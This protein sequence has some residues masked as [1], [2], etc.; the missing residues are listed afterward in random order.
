MKQFT[1]I[2]HDISC[3]TVFYKIYLVNLFRQR[4]FI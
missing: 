1:G 2:T 4:D 3:S